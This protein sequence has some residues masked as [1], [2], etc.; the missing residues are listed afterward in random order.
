M[1]VDPLLFPGH[2]HTTPYDFFGNQKTTQ[3]QESYNPIPRPKT[4]GIPKT[5]VCRILVLACSVEPRIIVGGL[6]NSQYLWSQNPNIRLQGPLGGFGGDGLGSMGVGG[7]K[8]CGGLKLYRI[9][10]THASGNSTGSYFDLHIHQH[11]L[12]FF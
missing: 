2:P 11:N 3:T 10:L 5:M 8:S 7:S 6:D 4:Q 9:Y 1:N 12:G